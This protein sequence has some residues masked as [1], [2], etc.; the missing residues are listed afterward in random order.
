MIIFF[1]IFI[2]HMTLR[3]NIKITITVTMKQVN[4]L[5]IVL[6]IPECHRK[7]F[8]WPFISWPRTVFYDVY[9]GL[10]FIAFAEGAWCLAQFMRKISTSIIM[11]PYSVQL[12]AFL[13]SGVCQ[14]EF[15]I[16]QCRLFWYVIFWIVDGC[17]CC[18]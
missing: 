9:C 18:F 2:L 1:L 14:T 8:K 5:Y 4:R 17:C 16:W 3:H 11:D 12:S 6:L 13:I 10:V 15:F 7:I